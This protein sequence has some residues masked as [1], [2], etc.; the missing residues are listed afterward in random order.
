[1]KKNYGILLTP[2]N[3]KLLACR[4]EGA[5]IIIDIFSKMIDTYPLQHTPLPK[6]CRKVP[7]GLP[8]NVPPGADIGTFLEHSSNVAVEHCTWNL[9]ASF[10]ERSGHSLA[11]VTERS[12]HSLAMITERS[13]YS[14]AMVTERSGH[15]LVLLLLLLSTCTKKFMNIANIYCNLINFPY[16]FYPFCNVTQ[17]LPKQHRYKICE[18][19]RDH[20]QRLSGTLRGMFHRGGH[21]NLPGTFH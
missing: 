6:A 15:S 12:G 10:M 20:C 21:R 7:W 3:S 5:V 13:E 4:K 16:I 8:W 11:M 14:L 19:F 9:P 17:M 1:M 2:S 18:Q